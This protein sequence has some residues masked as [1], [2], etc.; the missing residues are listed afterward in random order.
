M[1]A[2][3]ENTTKRKVL[4]VPAK[5]AIQYL[6]LFNGLFEMTGKELEV[7]AA[8]VTLHLA[9]L[10]TGVPVNA[11]AAEMRKRVAKELAMADSSHLNV[12][13]QRLRQKKAVEKIPGGY[14]IH[15]LLIPGGEKE[16]VFK[17]T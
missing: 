9:L 10:K 5:T 12:Y 6:Q 1:A 8:F 4:R 3:T 16:I 2:P 17:L 11:F 15:P 14:L 7:L 13:I